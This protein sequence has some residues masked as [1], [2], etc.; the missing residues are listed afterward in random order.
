MTDPK[1]PRLEEA[2]HRNLCDVLLEIRRR[3]PDW[4]LGQ[5]VCNLSTL[6]DSGFEVWDIE[7]EQLLD[8]AVRFLERHKDRVPDPLTS[9]SPDAA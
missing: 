4:R 8:S 5:L 6:S 1:Y 7:D 9:P 2:V 3:F